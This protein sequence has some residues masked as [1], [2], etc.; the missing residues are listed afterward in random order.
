LSQKPDYVLLDKVSQWV[1][2]CFQHL[3]CTRCIFHDYNHTRETVIA[4]KEIA[5][6]MQVSGDEL[7]TILLA[8]WFHDLGLLYSRENHEEI[9]AG[10]A[11]E[12]L[13]QQ[14]VGE[15]KIS[16]VTACIMATKMPQKPTTLLEK[17]VCDADISHLGQKDYCRKNA[18]LRREFELNRGKPYSDAEWWALNKDFFRQHNYF[19][20][21]ALQKYNARK[22][23][24]LTAIHHLVANSNESA[25]K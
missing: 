25:K 21:Y 9:S 23:A 20:P 2:A 17:I 12:F 18:R 10:K 11:E 16:A 3:H 24:N 5:E 14:A 1:A 8:C 7:E 4:G 13:R 15:E 19:T 6:G 22:M